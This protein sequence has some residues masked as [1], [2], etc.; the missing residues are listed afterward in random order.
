MK[1]ADLIE[2]RAAAHA[3]MTA[4]HEADDGTAFAAAE[5]EL[6]AVDAKLARA[7]ALDAADRAEQGRPI[8]GDAKLDSEIRSKFSVSRAIAHAA[9]LAVEAGFEREIQAELSKRAGRAPGG[10]FIPTEVF[11]TRVLTTATGSELVPTDHRPDQY[12][13]ALTAASVVRGLGARVLSGLIGAVS[14]PR[15]T[16]SP[17]IGFVAENAALSSDDAN[18]DSVTLSPKHA[19]ALTEYSRNM[20]LQASPDVEMLLRQMLA[21]NLALAI[22]RAAIRGGGANEPVGVLA[23]SGIQKVTN[24]GSI[25]DAVA[26]AV[27]LAD[28]ENVGARRSILTTP[29]LRKIAAKALDALDRPIGVATVFHDLP[30]TFSNQVPKTLGGGAEHGLIYADWTELLIGIWSEVDILVNPFESTAY[31][32]GNVSIRAMATVDVAVR[33]PKA[34]VSVEDVTVSTPAMPI[35]GLAS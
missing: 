1:L 20:L 27:A 10:I 24:P 33:H 17:V 26:D 35:T 28:A 22:D 15:E 21:R 32:K 16:A 6:R 18:F 3:R 34:F 19:G 12:V 9:G 11:E 14:I 25:F 5:N 4:A 31:S 29:E 7:R 23:T 8:N 2:S 30:R 13:N